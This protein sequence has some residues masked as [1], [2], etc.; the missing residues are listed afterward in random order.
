MY[1][2]GRKSGQSL[3]STT[4]CWVEAEHIYTSLIENEGGT[5]R[6]RNGEAQYERDNGRMKERQKKGM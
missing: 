6:P 5:E 2:G 3:A 1:I 4:E